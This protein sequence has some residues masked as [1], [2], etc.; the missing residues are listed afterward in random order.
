MSGMEP[1]AALGLVCNILQLVRLG[2][3]T[4]ACI[5]TIYQDGKLDQNLEQNAV[6]LEKLA[7]EIKKDS[8]PGNKKYERLLLESAKCCFSAAGQLQEELRFL[9]GDAKRGSLVSAVRVTTAVMW[10]QRRLERLS[11]NLEAEEKRLQTGLLAQ[12]W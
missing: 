10:R 11:R 12:V 7:N 3:K 6:V 4:I 8:Q 1:F 2:Q 9:F 5:K